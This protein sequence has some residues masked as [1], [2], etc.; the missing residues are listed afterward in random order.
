M[1]I[2]DFDLR[3]PDSA[4]A[5]ILS[6]L[7]V[8]GES[9]TTDYLVNCERNYEKFWQKHAERISTVDVNSIRIY[10]F[11]VCGSLDN[12]QSIKQNGLQN[13]QILLSTDS[14]IN[15]VFKKNGLSFKIQDK[16]MVYQ[17]REYNVDY[18]SYRN[19]HFLSD[20]DELLKSISYRLYYDY[21]V[22]GFMC[23][24]NVFSYGTD[25][26]ERP[27]FICDLVKM[28]PALSKMEFEWK[29][30]MTS[31]RVDFF[32]Y[33]KQLHRFNFDLDNYRDPPY[34]EWY[35]LDDNSRIL[36]WMLSH[37]IDRAFDDLGTEYL[38]IANSLSIPP[39]QIV[40]YA[41]IAY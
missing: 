2:L 8:D 18:E 39:E 4:Y 40:Q 24:D 14:I 37:A 7:K 10:A 17:G 20:T 19:R 32:A 15:R 3:T 36:K 28:F 5:F 22:N 1:T 12:C 31:Y 16:V 29:Q 11:H 34:E 33:V 23:N 30:Q 27:E 13:L 41:I 21:C 25:I 26:H 6:L 38:Y 35:D 9:F